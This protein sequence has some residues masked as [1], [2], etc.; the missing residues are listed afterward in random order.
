VK[1]GLELIRSSRGISDAVISVSGRPE[2]SRYLAGKFF[3]SASTGLVGLMFYDM[4]IGEAAKAKERKAVGE[5][6]A[7]MMMLADNTDDIIDK[8][9]TTLGE[10]FRFLD[11]VTSTMLGSASHSSE[12]VQEEASYALAR[13]L[14]KDFLSKYDCESLEVISEDLSDAA[15]RQ[16]TESNKEELLRIAKRIGSGCTDSSAVLTDMATGKEHD[17][18]RNSARRIGEY[19]TLLDNLYELNNDLKEGVNTYSTVRVREEGDTYVVRNDIKKEMLAV[20][21]ESLR[22]GFDGLDAKGKSTY[23]FLKGMIDFKYK[24]LKRWKN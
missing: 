23:N 21:G 3:D 20:A 14:H 10:K 19:S 18:A 9:Q 12:D 22:Q 6:S 2:V 5:A 15:K 16:F 17:I 24:I 13:S 1:Y 11:D 8:R 4:G 7:R